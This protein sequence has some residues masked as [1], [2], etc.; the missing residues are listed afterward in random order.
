[1]KLHETKLSDTS[2]I[3]RIVLLVAFI[4]LLM[5]SSLW[6]L[7]PFL[8]ATI[9]AITIVVSTWPW[10]IAVQR[11][12]RGKRG[13]AVTIMMLGLALAVLLPLALGFSTIVSLV[14]QVGH[15]TQG[16]ENM[17]V[18]GPPQ[19]LQGIPLVGNELTNTWQRMAQTDL[20]QVFTAV[21]PYL[22]TGGALLASTMGS[23][24]MFFVHLSL[25]VINMKYLRSAEELTEIA[26]GLL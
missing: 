15:W 18:P 3:P 26:I 14:N 11:R 17:Q 8:P 1:M 13:W 2:D 25:T 7:A 23:F 19:W 4:A 9:W 5:I 10:L 24:G 6:I 22:K 16:L 20:Q 21:K 12:V